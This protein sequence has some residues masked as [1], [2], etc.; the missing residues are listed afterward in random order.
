MDPG[1]TVINARA[2]A[3]AEIGGVERWAREMAVRLPALRPEGYFVARPP[4]A[5][6]HKAGHLWEQGVLPALA[7][8]RGAA[9]L[10]SPANATGARLA[11]E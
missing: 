7:R 10:Y 5:L 6:A 11:G 8:R 3:R 4:R 1:L 2:A 9:L